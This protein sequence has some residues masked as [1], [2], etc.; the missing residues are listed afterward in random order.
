MIVVIRSELVLDIKSM[1]DQFGHIQNLFLHVF[2][3]TLK[4]VILKISEVRKMSYDLQDSLRRMQNIYG[5]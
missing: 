5:T 4:P 3:H 1:K 2:Q